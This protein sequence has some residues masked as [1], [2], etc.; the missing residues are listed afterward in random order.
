MCKIIVTNIQRFSL[1]DG[2]GIRT[3]VFLKGCYI[4]CPWCSNP[5][6]ISPRYEE[7]IQNGIGGIYGKAYSSK[8]LFDEIIKDHIFYDETGGVTFSGGE[9]LLQAEVILTVLKMLKREKITVAVETSLFAPTNKLNMI[10]PYVDYFLVDMKIMD[11]EKCKKIIKGDIVQYKKN[12][13]ILTSTRNITVRIPVIAGY[14]DCEENRKMI[15]NELKRLQKSI[16]KVELIKE[17]H[18][19]VSKYESLNLA[20]PDYYGVSDNIMINYKEE[21]ESAVN[22]LV[23]ICKV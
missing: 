20:L 4:C 10:L 14:T 7:Y 22:I 5:E 13:D 3:T 8:E 12:L 21:I 23:E 9:V 17:H 2:P 11:E 16:I 15:I 18:L 6:N 1:H 19:G